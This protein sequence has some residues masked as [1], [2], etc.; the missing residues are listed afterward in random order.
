M[1]SHEGRLLAQLAQIHA[2]C[3]SQQAHPH[4]HLGRIGVSCSK[5]EEMG[6]LIRG[7]SWNSWT[8]TA[9]VAFRCGLTPA[10]AGN[11]LSFRVLRRKR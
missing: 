5:E 11:Y 2:G 7:G 9:R 8:I 4:L 6:K 3:H 1:E 10:R